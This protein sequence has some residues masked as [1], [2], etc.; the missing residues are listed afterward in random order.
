MRRSNGSTDLRRPRAAD[1]GLEATFF[2]GDPRPTMRRVLLA[3]LEAFSEVGYHG[4]TTRDI[5]RR[6]QVSA[7]GLYTH[8]SSKD[9]LLGRIITVTHEAMLA[10]M[11]AVFARPGDASGRLRELVHAHARF[12]ATHHTAARV[13]NY[14][15]QS[16]PAEKRA[17]IMVLRRDME[18][19]MGEAL[20]LGIVSGDFDVPNP[21]L[22]TMSILSLGIDVSRWYRPGKQ[23]KPDDIGAHHA[24]LVLRMVERREAR[25]PRRQAARRVAS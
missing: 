11:R 15:L 18:G 25:E 6:A 5:A 3:A 13:A 8:Y 19:V 10:E 12:H 22:M 4:T 9:A 2:D 1:G 16:L 23:L 20:R 14:E 7:A 21:Q 24:D 17:E